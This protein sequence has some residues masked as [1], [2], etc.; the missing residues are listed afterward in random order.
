M[1]QIY[2]NTPIFSLFLACGR[3][4][5]RAQLP[6]ERRLRNRKR[7][8][9][10]KWIIIAGVA[11]ACGLGAQAASFTNLN[12]EAYAG[13]GDDLLPGWERSTGDY[14]WPMVDFCPLVT[15]GLGLVTIQAECGILFE[16]NYSAF[17][18]SGIGVWVY[19]E[20][21]DAWIIGDPG[22]VTIRQTAQVPVN[23]TAVRYSSTP[24]VIKEPDDLGDS[25]M[26]VQGMLGGIDLSAGTPAGLGNGGLR[27]TT[28]I[29]S[30]A[31]QT[32]QLSFYLTGW[33]HT[34]SPGSWHSLDQIEFLDADGAV[35]WPLPPPV[36]LEDFHAGTLNTSLWEVAISGQTNAYSLGGQDLRT[37]V[38]PPPAPFET[39]YRYRAEL[40]GDWDVQVDYQFWTMLT[41]STNVGVLGTALAAEFGSGGTSKASV[42]R[43]VDVDAT[44]HR[45]A[46]DWGQGPTGDLATTAVTGTFRLVRTGWEVAGYVWDAG[47]NDWQIVG[48]MDGY[49]DETAR[50]GLKV[51][52]T[53]AFSGKGAYVHSDNLMLANGRASLAGLAV[54]TFGLDGAGAPTVAWDSA[55][56]PT[57]TRVVVTRATSLVDSVWKPV[58]GA[59]GDAGG[60]TN[61]TGSGGVE[62]PAYYRLQV[63]PGN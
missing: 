9:V 7:C 54:K 3:L 10:K 55:G 36:R 12:F 41:S 43:L 50:V 24:T 37:L 25:E 61:W 26:R 27:Y 1:G 63:V 52:S 17:I 4:A 35:V 11:V 32:V 45:Y 2:R 60:E 48:T 18:S 20:R 29:S 30:L 53:G 15:A 51:W 8:A 39:V 42:G 62:G 23:A 44:D 58:S 38:M 57:N 22:K 19:D 33:D 14:M 40:R 16:G 46:V 21:A 47:S 34:R 31:G 56:M 6:M 5:G 28:D 59:I 13:T 49:T